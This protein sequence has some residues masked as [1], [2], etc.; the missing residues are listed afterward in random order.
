QETLVLQLTRLFDA[1]LIHRRQ[2]AQQL[3]QRRGV[4][5]VDIVEK[6]VRPT[7]RHQELEAIRGMIAFEAHVDLGFKRR[8]VA[9]LELAVLVPAVALEHV[10]QELAVAPAQRVLDLLPPAP[11]I[12][13]RR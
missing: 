7:T 2:L 13:P 3:Q 5:Y 1:Q 9:E 10:L 12:P 11:V 8:E 6:A 4:L